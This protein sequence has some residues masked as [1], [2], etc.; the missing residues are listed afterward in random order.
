MK[1]KTQYVGKFIYVTLAILT[2]VALGLLL[3]P[4]AVPV[5]IAVVEQGPFTEQLRVDGTVRSR[6]I[7]T[8]TA[9]ATGDLERLEMKAGES[10]KKGQTLTH[11]KW[12]FR[13]PVT[14]PVA[15]VVA[16]VYRESAGPIQR[17]EP[18]VDIIDPRDIEVVAKVLTTDAVKVQPQSVVKIFGLGDDSELEGRVL[19]VSQA[20]F[21]EISALGIEEEKT[22]I[23]IE[24]QK[25]PPVQIG[26]NFHV[27]L[28]IEVSHTDQALQV[29]LGALLKNRNNWAVYTVQDQRAHLQSVE[30]AKRN[31]SHAVVSSGLKAGEQVILFPGDQVF[32]NSKVKIRRNSHPDP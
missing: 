31:D 26:H 1:K 14:S 20:G 16:K 15:G 8:V 21:V 6:H 18:I 3:R 23:F 9:F 5:E 4:S 19:R 22:E 32:D 2:A 10:V 30:I 7:T 28:L 27:E 13:K 24:F 12:D 29:P 17:G 11:L 25:P